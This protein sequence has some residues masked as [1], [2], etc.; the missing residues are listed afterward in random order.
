[1]EETP[2]SEQFMNSPLKWGSIKVIGGYRMNN[3]V[4]VQIN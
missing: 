4:G 2:K 3:R 1:M